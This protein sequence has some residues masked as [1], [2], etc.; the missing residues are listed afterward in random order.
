[1]VVSVLYAPVYPSLSESAS[2]HR[3]WLC[4]LREFPCERVESLSQ[5]YDWHTALGAGLAVLLV[6]KPVP[7]LRTQ[8]QNGDDA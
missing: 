6:W 4:E 7:S 2:A 3:I 8:V 5:L 1:M